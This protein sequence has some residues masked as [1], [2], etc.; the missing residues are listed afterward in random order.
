MAGETSPLGRE[1]PGR[2]C[3]RRDSRLEGIQV[4]DW[5]HDHKIC[6]RRLSNE[7]RLC[8]VMTILLAFSKVCNA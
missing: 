3:A 4:S 7:P 2:C 6:A 5:I 8:S 1:G